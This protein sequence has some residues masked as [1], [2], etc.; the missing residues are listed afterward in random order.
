M[1]EKVLTI[2]IPM[3]NMEK[4]IDQCLSS[5][6]FGDGMERMEVLVINDGSKD[7]CPAIAHG[8]E[9]RCPQTFRVIDKENGNY[10]S[11]INR[12]VAEATGKY[13]RVLDAD[14]FYE[15]KNLPDFVKFLQGTDLD[16]VYTKFCR[17]DECG[18]MI[19]RSRVLRKSGTVYGLSDLYPRLHMAM[20]NITY[21]TEVLRRIAYRQTE[22]ISY[23]D[24]EWI[25]LPMAFV[26]RWQYYPEIIYIYRSEREGQTMSPERIVRDIDQE[27]QGMM[28]MANHYER[29][30]DSLSSA[31]K[32][33]LKNRLMTRARLIYKRFLLSYYNEL[34]PCMSKLVKMDENIRNLSPEIWEEM[35][36]VCFHIFIFKYRFIRN[37]RKSG[38][39]GDLWGLR[40]KR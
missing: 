17:V 5:L 13:I 34:K 8:Y 26:E 15:T 25:F 10:G 36:N 6:C 20:H 7:N 11:C 24:Q 35:E 27:M 2:I 39:N 33:Y 4:Y 16:M 29:L 12:G 37:W 38:Y 22:G 40:F 23:T 9:A 1:K 18:N 31:Q 19:W 21:R 14:D 3:Y 32:G 28:V 30:K